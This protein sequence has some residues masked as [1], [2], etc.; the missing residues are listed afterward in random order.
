MKAAES[1]KLYRRADLQDPEKGTDL[2]G[3]KLSEV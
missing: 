3:A 2:N 1:L